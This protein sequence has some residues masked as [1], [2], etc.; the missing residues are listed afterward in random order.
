MQTLILHY[1]IN[2]FLKIERRVYYSGLKQYFKLPQYLKRG[3]YTA[4]IKKVLQLPDSIGIL[5][6]YKVLGAV[7]LFE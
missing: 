5:F 6:C 4:E 3:K 1:S 2:K 7:K